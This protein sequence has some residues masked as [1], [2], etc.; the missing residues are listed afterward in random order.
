MGLTEWEAKG[1]KSMILQY[2]EEHIL[3]AKELEALAARGNGRRE[4]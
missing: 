2:Y 1:L 4:K 3:S